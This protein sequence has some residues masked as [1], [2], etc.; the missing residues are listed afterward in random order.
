[1]FEETKD[2]TFRKGDICWFE[3]PSPFDDNS[4]IQHGPRP[5]VIVSC[6]RLNETSTLATIVPMTTNVQKKLYPN[7]IEI[8]LNGTRSRIKCDQIRV[9][10]KSSLAAPH[11]SLDLA[12]MGALDNALMDALGIEMDSAGTARLAAVSEY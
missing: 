5:V 2:Y 8:S 6:N 10:D 1:M 12:A 3:D 11:A 9:V 4:H 7:Q